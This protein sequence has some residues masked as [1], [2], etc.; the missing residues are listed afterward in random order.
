MKLYGFLV[1][2]ATFSAVM[3][4]SDGRTSFGT[5]FQDLAKD[6]QVEFVR[7]VNKSMKE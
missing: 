6:D 3:A 4:A 2:A 5:A 1:A 7:A